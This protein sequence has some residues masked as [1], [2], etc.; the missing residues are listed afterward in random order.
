[1]NTEKEYQENFQKLFSLAFLCREA[2]RKFYKSK[3][4]GGPF[5]DKHLRAAMA[6]ER[7]LDSFINNCNLAAVKTCFPQDNTLKLF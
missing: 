5:T 2:Q 6:A 3:K 1:M 4:S 7:D